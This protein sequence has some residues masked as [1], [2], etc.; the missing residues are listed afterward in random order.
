MLEQRIDTTSQ[1]RW[2]AHKQSIVSA[3]PPGP[4]YDFFR[5][6]DRQSR[7]ASLCSLCLS[8][9][10]D[11]VNVKKLVLAVWISDKET[12]T[13]PVFVALLNICNT[14]A[15]PIRPWLSSEMKEDG[16][17]SLNKCIKRDAPNA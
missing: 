14:S 9:L 10:D 4:Q 15:S 7:N 12:A 16:V 3:S 17:L 11:P 5:T 2:M 8:F 6:H 13:F 1:S